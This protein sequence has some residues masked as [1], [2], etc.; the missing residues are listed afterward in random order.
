M[1]EKKS[2]TTTTRGWTIA[3]VTQTES[4]HKL[5]A[6]IDGDLPHISEEEASAFFHEWL[7]ECDRTEVADDSTISEHH[8]VGIALCAVMANAGVPEYTE[9]SDVLGQHEKT[10]M[11]H[12]GD[13]ASLSWQQLVDVVTA[14]QMEV[15]LFVSF[16]PDEG[17][18][19]S[20]DCR[21]FVMQLMRRVGF[22]VTHEFKAP[23]DE[24]TDD[25]ELAHGILEVVTDNWTAVRIDDLGLVLDA[26]HSVAGLAE[27]LLGAQLVVPETTSA[28]D[29]LPLFN[30]HREASLD[31]FYELSMT[32][33]LMPGT[34]IQYKR[35][36]KHL[37]HSISQVVYFHYPHYSRQVQIPLAQIQKN[38]CNHK[39]LLPLLQQSNPDIKIL[40]EHTGAAQRVS[41]RKHPRSWCCM[42]G[43]IV[44]ATPEQVFCASDL[45][46]LVLHAT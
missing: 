45:R 7:D 17:F 2:H 39:N 38:D 4:L 18:S 9:I 6:L 46:T 22:F 15:S 14:L 41:H 11:V 32:S 3:D 37:F 23:T 21:S 26:L 28:Q 19:C 34:I 25:V 8:T 44:L 36:F 42:A 10:I 35:K 16:S 33:D 30:H 24:N 5:T 1:S 40:F 12:E 43:F 31:D 20:L 27:F 29:E 13:I